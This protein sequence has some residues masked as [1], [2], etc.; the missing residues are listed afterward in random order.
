MRVAWRAFL[1]GGLILVPGN[2]EHI[3]AGSE[4]SNP[5]QKGFRLYEM[6]YGLCV[7]IVSQSCPTLCDPWVVACQ[8]PLAMRIL[9]ERMLECIAMPSSRGSF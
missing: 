8:A 7:C 2:I 9:Q 6:F 3:H 1:I 4:K 5:K